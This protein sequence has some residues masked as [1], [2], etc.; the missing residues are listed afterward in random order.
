MKPGTVI[1]L[2]AGICLLSSFSFFSC[3]KEKVEKPFAEAVLAP[4]KTDT[5]VNGTLK[6]FEEKDGRVTLQLDIVVP[7]KRNS[8]VA[9][10]LHEHGMCGNAGGDAHGHWN[11]T[12]KTH[13]MWGSGSFH[14]G[15]IGN[16]ALDANGRGVL[17][18][19]TDL[20]TLSGEA[21]TNIIGK[22]VIVHSGVDDYT[23]QPAGN[24][25]PRIGCGVIEPRK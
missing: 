23:S 2:A 8:T 13:G 1:R 24:S 4:T 20:W 6:F 15:D 16:I 18:L 14:A 21:P 25:G 11:P 9:V 22:G 17:R 12:G 7:K 19:T 10:H 3:K 5:A